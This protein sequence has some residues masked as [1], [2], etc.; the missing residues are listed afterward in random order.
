MNT[1]VSEPRKILEL[2]PMNFLTLQTPRIPQEHI[3][4][5]RNPW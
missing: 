3:T 1:H 2:L 5:L 4:N